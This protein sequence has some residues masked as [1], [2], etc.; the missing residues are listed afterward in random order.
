MNILKKISILAV[1]AVVVMF[2]LAKV[3]TAESD[4]DK[5]DELGKKIEEYSQQITRLQGEASTLSNQIAQFNAQINLAELRIA[6]TESQINLLGGRID[7][8]EVSLESLDEAFSSRVEQMYKMTRLDDTA[9]VVMLSS[10]NIS[11]AVSTYYYL[12]KIQEADKILLGR[13]TDARDTYT[14]QKVELE[15]LQEVL[16]TQKAELDSQK[17]A[18]ASLLAVTRNDE[19][20]YQELLSQAK[21]EYQAIQAIIA[22]SGDEEEVGHVNT[23]EKIASV[24]QG[25]S[26]NSSGGHLHFIVTQGND[27]RNP[28][29]FLNNNIS[30]QNCSGPGACNPGDPFNPGGSWEWPLNSPIKYSQGYGA[31]WA[32][33]NTW[34]GRIYN[35]HNGIDINNSSNPTVKAVQPGTLYRGSFSGSG[36]CRLRYVRVDHDDSDIDTYYLHINY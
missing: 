24:I 26:C 3:T 33:Y 31:T 29:D 27:V 22:G 4:T 20:R 14:D 8:L 17:T 18:K 11:E 9:P 15:D 28:F 5:L 2:S 7:Q 35:F 21:E 36:G 1:V 25:A 12:Q 10:S 13:L 23:G 30:A 6:Q 16:T 32:V 19:A 34:V